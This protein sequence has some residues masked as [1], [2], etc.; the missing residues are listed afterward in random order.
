MTEKV[1]QT[2]ERTRGRWWK[3][4]LTIV[5][6]LS[7][8]VGALCCLTL[9]IAPDQA[10]IVIW[11]IPAQ[12]AWLIAILGGAVGGLARALYQFLLDNYAFHYLRIAKRSSPWAK[13]VYGFK[14]DNDMDDDYDP[15]ESWELFFVKPF[16]GATLGLL[17]ALAVELGLL[18][19]GGDIAEDKRFL[20]LVVTAGLA[21]L[22]AENVLQRLERLLTKSG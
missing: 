11:S 9:I 6:L 18:G 7:L 22:F 10:Q 12:R 3:L 8:T 2:L 13:R 21:G 4:P 16:V 20:R 5:G 1:R 15:L 14:D 17:F 19:L